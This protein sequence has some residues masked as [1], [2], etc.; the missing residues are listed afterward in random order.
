MEIMGFGSEHRYRNYCK[1]VDALNAGNKTPKSVVIC[2]SGF[3]R[4]LFL[5]TLNLDKL[6]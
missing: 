3:S 4:K 1:A 2:T 5:V 6:L